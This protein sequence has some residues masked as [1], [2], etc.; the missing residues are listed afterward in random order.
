VL[1]EGPVVEQG[2]TVT[3][4]VTVTFSDRRPVWDLWWQTPASQASV[5]RWSL[6][7]ALCSLIPALISLGQPVQ[8]HV[9]G[10][11]SPSLAWHLTEYMAMW[12]Q[13]GPYH[14]CTF[15]A[16]HWQEPDL[17]CQPSHGISSFSGGADSCHTAWVLSQAKE[18]LPC[19][20]GGL[21]LVHG[22]DIPLTEQ[23]GFQQ[24]YHACKRQADSIGLPLYTVTTNIRRYLDPL[25]NWDLAF[26]AVVAGCFRLFSGQFGYGVLPS[27]L[28]Y[29]MAH[30]VPHGSNPITDGLL[31]SHGF[32]ITLFGSQFTRAEKLRQIVPWQAGLANLRVCYQPTAYGHNCGKCRKCLQ[33]R[34]LLDAW[35][36]TNP[37][38]FPPSAASLHT[39]I[40]Q[41]TLANDPIVMAVYGNVVQMAAAQPVPPKWLALLRR[42]LKIIQWRH[43][44]GTVL[45]KLGLRR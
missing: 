4:P 1:N 18:P 41:L 13:W 27:G 36:V 16:D 12:Q 8:V 45:R 37:A 29:S 19:Q 32:R 23:A 3:Y 35:G 22:L 9:A 25:I 40:R 44:V 21:M 26:G 38:C 28:D 30:H 43:R 20:L 10:S 2:D 42:R 39:L 14:P 11:L 33:T 31:S 34:L 17:P 15:S 6:D 24:A 7:V 5:V